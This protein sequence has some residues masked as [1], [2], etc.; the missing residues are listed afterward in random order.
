[1]KLARGR[2]RERERDTSK[3]EISETFKR[4][5]GERCMCTTERGM[6]EREREA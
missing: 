1:V 2:E 4:G 5:R 3:R 6:N